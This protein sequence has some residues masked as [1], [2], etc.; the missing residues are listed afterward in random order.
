MANVPAYF[1]PPEGIDSKDYLFLM[2]GDTPISKP[3]SLLGHTLTN[4]NVEL[5]DALTV[6]R[7]ELRNGR[8]RTIV[9]TK[10]AP[11]V[12]S[13]TYTIGF[14]P[15]AL[16]TPAMHAALRPG[17]CRKTFYMKYLC[18][19]D[20]R[21]EHVEI[22]P[23]GL[24]DPPQEEG[25]LIT[26][27][28]ENIIGMTSTLNVTERI[29]AWNLGW[30]LIFTDGDGSPLNGVGFTTADCPTCADVPGLGLIAAGGV[31]GAEDA[32]VALLTDDRFASTPTAMTTGIA[33]GNVVKTVYTDGA[34]VLLGFADD[35]AIATAATGGI[36]RSNDG[37]LSFAAVSG[38]TTP[39]NKI[40][41]V[42]DVIVAVG[43][44]GAGAPTIHFSSD[45]GASWTAS[46]STL[47]AGTDAL[48]SGAYDKDAD[49]IYFVGEGGTLLVGQLTGDTLVLT[50]IS[51]NLPG[52][53]GTL[54]AVNV[55]F[56]D[57]VAVG[58]A[59]GYYAESFDGAVEF[60]EVAVPGS[61]AITAIAGNQHRAVVAAGTALYER[62]P[63]NDFNYEAVVLGNGVTV[64]GDY[65]AVVMGVDGDFNMFAAVTDDGEVV[66]G[67][68]Y[69]PNA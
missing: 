62:D 38:I 52:A 53:P 10:R 51:A 42:G 27:D 63:L 20:T 57:H 36:V 44:T 65:T 7:V 33:D 25:D 13:R 22:M 43:G 1:G 55:F 59:A 58:G 9:R 30:D 26:V 6:T 39:I 66:V 19:D 5:S 31:G 48:V 21:F 47:L 69:Y 4:P 17:G 60:V 16:W 40:F 24:L 45:K 15:G 29:R 8:I 50:D 54:N 3:V 35:P 41:A 46:T 56:K 67:K 34:T 14:P 37:G 61:A 49:R 2:A 18:P 23:D 64:T 12:R 28:E 68:P 11:E 32:V